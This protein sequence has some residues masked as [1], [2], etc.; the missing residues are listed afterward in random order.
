MTMR[1][2]RMGE[3][4]QVPPPEKAVEWLRAQGLPETGSTPGRR[5]VVGSPAVVRDA[6]ELIAEE[7]G[8]EEVIVVTIT[9]DHE[10]R[11]RSYELLADV[12]ELEPRGAD[13]TAAAPS[14]L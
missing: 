7:Y 1:L 4:I 13:L 11:R 9:F 2:L 14:P 3:L 12:M 10:A 5:A 6:L 8:A